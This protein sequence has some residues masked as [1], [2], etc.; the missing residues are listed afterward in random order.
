[1]I[2]C[3]S[4]DINLG[5]CKGNNKIKFKPKSKEDLYTVPVTKYIL[6]IPD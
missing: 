2:K 5:H 3:A 6:V 4:L 1:M